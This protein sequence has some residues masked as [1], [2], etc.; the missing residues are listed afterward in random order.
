MTTAAKDAEL[1]LVDLDRHSL[2]FLDALWR[3]GGVSRDLDESGDEPF[4]VSSDSDRPSKSKLEQRRA[5]SH[6]V[7]RILL[8][9]HV[10]LID[11]RKPFRKG[12]MGKPILADGSVRFSLAHSG[13]RALIGM[14][15]DCE[16][17]VD[18]EAPREPR[19]PDHRRQQ[20]IEAG[21]IVARGAPL[22]QQSADHTLLQAWVRLEAMAKA[23]G[24]GMGRLLTRYRIVGTDADQAE[25]TV[26]PA[27]LA[28]A[29]PFLVRDLL[30]DRG[31]VAAVAGN[32]AAMS[33]VVS[34][35]PETPIA[36]AAL[37]RP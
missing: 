19:F 33:A 16:I 26:P 36:I 21:I 15:S 10:G 11:A 37:V 34:M 30:L 5:I 1:W 17:G 9:R 7:L 28:G 3:D 4:T 25:L 18:L 8:A 14:T 20:L 29:E 6:L 2:D 24:E 31:F 32:P 22:P 35:F 23:T 12:P 13:D 27:H